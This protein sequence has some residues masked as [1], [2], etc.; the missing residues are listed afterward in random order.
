MKTEPAI[1]LVIALGS[2]FFFL[3]LL[4]L[5]VVL[6]RLRA[7][8]ASDRGTGLVILGV[9]VLTLAFFALYIV[10]LVAVAFS[11]SRA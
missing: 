7:L 9:V 1:L 2:V 4:P 8:L 6:A 11:G 10:G 5:G 3:L